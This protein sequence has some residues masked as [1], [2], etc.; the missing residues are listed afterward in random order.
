MFP[1]RNSSKKLVVINKTEI[2]KIL[3]LTFVI[4][5]CTDHCYHKYNCSHSEYILF[6]YGCSVIRAT[7]ISVHR[8]PFGTCFFATK[9][10]SETSETRILLLVNN[11]PRRKASL[12]L[13][14]KWMEIYN[15]RVVSYKYR[16]YFT[17]KLSS[18][19]DMFV[20]HI[21][22]FCLVREK[23]ELYHLQRYPS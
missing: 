8:N 19:G 5:L 22:F 2:V 11:G 21:L 16:F 14:M 3:M 10:M 7:Y 6:V 9:K 17:W 4:N 12:L 13:R 15:A 23:S 18:Y 20:A 1:T